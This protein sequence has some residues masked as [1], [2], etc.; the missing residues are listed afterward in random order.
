MQRYL[1]VLKEDR[2]PT[3]IE[4]LNRIIN[5]IDE[6]DYKLEFENLLDYARD[7]IELT[8]FELKK[9]GK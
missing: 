5:L 3:P 9:R 2:D 8:I 1:K 4:L 7:Y 6:V